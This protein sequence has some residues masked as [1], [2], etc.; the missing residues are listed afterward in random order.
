MSTELL[1]TGSN[2][3]TSADFDVASAETAN[4]F[5]KGVGTGTS[6]EMVFVEI[7]ADDDT[8]TPFATL[9]SDRALITLTGPGTF[10]VRRADALAPRAVG[11]S[12]G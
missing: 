12:L 10:R 2:A 4:V 9:G 6:P 8:Y 1:A 11:V 3:A 5:M 7:K